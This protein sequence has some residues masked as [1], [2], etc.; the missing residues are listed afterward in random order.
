MSTDDPRKW[1]GGRGKIGVGGKGGGGVG[2]GGMRT[3]ERHRLTRV[4][5]DPVVPLVDP[6]I[7]PP[8]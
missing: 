4:I 1:P 2:E 6:I 8:V 3:A 5:E 7:A